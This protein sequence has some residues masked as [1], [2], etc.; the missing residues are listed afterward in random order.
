[1]KPIGKCSPTLHFH[2][3]SARSSAM[4]LTVMATSVSVP[5][6][7]SMTGFAAKPGTAVLP[8]QCKASPRMHGSLFRVSTYDELIFRQASY[9]DSSTWT[10]NL[11][12]SPSRT[13][14]YSSKEPHRLVLSVRPRGWYTTKVSVSVTADFPSIW[15]D[16]LTSLAAGSSAWR[17]PDTSLYPRAKPCSSRPWSHDSSSTSAQAGM[18]QQSCA[19][20]LQMPYVSK[21][22]RMH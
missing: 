18:E 19:V 2:S 5:T 11:P 20:N 16:S 13:L 3:G 21:N 8:I 22:S 10:E 1:M 17:I 4:D 7:R 9:R 14:R 12:T 6:S 15:T